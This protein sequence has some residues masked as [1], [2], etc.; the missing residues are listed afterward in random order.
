MIKSLPKTPTRLAKESSKHHKSPREEG[1]NN[2]MSKF[3]T[4]II[5]NSQ[6]QP[7]HPLN[8]Q[9]QELTK[10]QERSS[11]NG[12]SIKRQSIDDQR[13]DLPPPRHP[14]QSPNIT[15]SKSKL[16]QKSPNSAL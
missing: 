10:N 4:T 3:N 5:K 14:K 11:F 16:N 15:K 12:K 1:I 2:P 7:I 6:E 13:S 9:E 8:K